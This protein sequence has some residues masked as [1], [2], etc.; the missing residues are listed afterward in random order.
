MKELNPHTSHQKYRLRPFFEILLLIAVLRF[1][2]VS[3]SLWRMK[4]SASR[5]KK[6]GIPQQG[7]RW[8]ISGSN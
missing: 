1:D 3:M 5:T 2:L 7:T 8:L 4:N 6:H